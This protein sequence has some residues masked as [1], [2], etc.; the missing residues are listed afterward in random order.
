MS[1]KTIFDMGK[2]ISKQ[3]ETILITP[4]NEEN[5]F[6]IITEHFNKQIKKSL[7]IAE[8]FLGK[9]HDHFL[10]KDKK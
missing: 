5:N 7:C 1:K 2:N 6:S 10:K 4:C 8:R 3:P 9:S